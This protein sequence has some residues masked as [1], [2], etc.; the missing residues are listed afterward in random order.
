MT[1]GG[2]AVVGIEGGKIESERLGIDNSIACFVDFIP[3][4]FGGSTPL[5][6]PWKTNFQP[7]ELTVVRGLQNS[8]LLL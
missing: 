8:R 2:Q 7:K 6:E 1:A 5:F 3:S 4:K